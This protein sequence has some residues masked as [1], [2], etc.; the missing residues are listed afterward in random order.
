MGTVRGLRCRWPSTASCESIF[1]MRSK[2]C[3]DRAGRHRGAHSRWHGYLQSLPQRT[4]PIA[5]LWGIDEA[6]KD[7][8]REAH[9]DARQAAA[10]A[11]GT[12]MV[13]EFLGEE[14]SSVLV[15]LYLFVHDFACVLRSPGC[16]W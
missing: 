15:R 2:Q 10:L 3:S 6:W 16:L 9:D 5:L 7:Q 11:A 8:G 1:S 14:S 12:E 13:G 4:V